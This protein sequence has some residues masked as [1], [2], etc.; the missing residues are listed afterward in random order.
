MAKHKSALKQLRGSK[1][2]KIRNTRVRSKIKSQFHKAELGL[3]TQGGNQSDIQEAISTIQRAAS[4]GVVHKNK[5]ARHKS[6]L[7]AAIKAL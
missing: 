3:G 5:A 4:R 1:R 7:T 6:R 2:R